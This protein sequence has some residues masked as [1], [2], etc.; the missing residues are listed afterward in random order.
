[1]ANAA[2]HKKRA[3]LTSTLDLEWGRN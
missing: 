1:M 2:F 3:L